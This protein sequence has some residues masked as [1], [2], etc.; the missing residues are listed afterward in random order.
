LF[1]HVKN[2]HH[3]TP[4]GFD[5]AG[6]LPIV[7]TS[8]L[9]WNWNQTLIPHLEL[10]GGRH[11]AILL[12]YGVSLSLV[13]VEWGIRETVLPHSLQHPNGVGLAEEGQVLVPFVLRSQ[14]LYLRVVKR[15]EA[16]LTGL[17]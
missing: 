6:Y 4:V 1:S 11:A 5:C 15:L 14:F 9:A 12:L 7:E 3:V 17:A 8:L 2:I 16:L 10:N 13:D